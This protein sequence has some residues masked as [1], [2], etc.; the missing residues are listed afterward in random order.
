MAPYF[1]EHEK[2]EIAHPKFFWA[3]PLVPGESISWYPKLAFGCRTCYLVPQN[4]PLLPRTRKK[5]NR[6]LE[7]FAGRYQRR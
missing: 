1:Q 7:I 2:K 5:G 3:V 6:L 4:G